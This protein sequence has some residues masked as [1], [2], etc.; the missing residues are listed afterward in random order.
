MNTVAGRAT[1]N[2]LNPKLMIL[3]L[4][5][6]ML[7]VLPPSVVSSTS[8][9][10]RSWSIFFTRTL[11][12]FEI[13]FLVVSP[14]GRT[15]DYLHYFLF[16]LSLV[17]FFGN[18]LGMPVSPQTIAP[19]SSTVSNLT[20]VSTSNVVAKSEAVSEVRGLLESKDGMEPNAELGSAPIESK[21]VHPLLKL[22]EP[23]VN[24]LLSMTSMDDATADAMQWELIVDRGD[25]VRIWRSKQNQHRYRLLG[26]FNAVSQILRM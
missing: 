21:E 4:L 26:I 6:V 14:L 9:T 19:S 23:L 7:L 2:I 17:A 24:K 3:A 1:S 5:K 11:F 20:T 13:Q 10:R 18:L 12:T 22:L 15:W 25:S 8:T 16:E